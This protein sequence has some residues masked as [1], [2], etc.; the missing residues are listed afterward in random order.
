V[1]ELID[2]IALR[3]ET[4][5]SDSEGQLLSAYDLEEHAVAVSEIMNKGILF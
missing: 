4:E 2:R 1:Q 3:V 5:R